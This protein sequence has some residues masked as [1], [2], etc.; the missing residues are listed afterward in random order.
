[1][2]AITRHLQEA[3]EQNPGVTQFSM[4]VAPSIHA[5]TKYMAG[6]SKFK[7]NVDILTFTITEFIEQI[8]V[9]ER[10]AEMLPA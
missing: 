5:D 4:L 10:I 6:Y 2:P 1:M 8:S 3:I 9:K 7:Y